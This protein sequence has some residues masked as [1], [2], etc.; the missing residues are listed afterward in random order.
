MRTPRQAGKS[1][2]IWIYLKSVLERNGGVPDKPW[3]IGNTGSRVMWLPTGE[4]KSLEQE[5]DDDD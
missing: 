2:A 5:N 4:V 3:V 1:R